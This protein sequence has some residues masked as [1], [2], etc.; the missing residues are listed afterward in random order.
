MTVGWSVIATVAIVLVVRALVGLW[1][2]PESETEG[3]D[4]TAHGEGSYNL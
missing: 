2:D 4:L 1:V 3:L